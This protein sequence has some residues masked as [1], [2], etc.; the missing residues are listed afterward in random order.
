MTIRAESACAKKTRKGANPE[1]AK[2]QNIRVLRELR[3]L[4]R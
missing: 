4:H 1:N 3:V 2:T